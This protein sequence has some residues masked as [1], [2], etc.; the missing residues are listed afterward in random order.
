MM[1]RLRL[2]LL[3]LFAGACT[4]DVG[5]LDPG[6]GDASTPTDAAS[7]G[8]LPTDVGLADAGT[9][10][11]GHEDVG[12][13]DAGLVRCADLEEPPPRM[14]ST[15]PECPAY[16]ALDP[17]VVNTPAASYFGETAAIQLSGG[18]HAPQALY[19]RTKEE[20][21]RIMAHDPRLTAF[22][23]AGTNKALR[24]SFVITPASPEVAGRLVN[25]T[26]PEWACLAPWV[27]GRI[28]P[29]GLAPG[30]GNLSVYIDGTFDPAW[31]LERMR[32]LDGVEQII[33][34][35]PLGPGV[36]VA[37]IVA[38]GDTH[39]Y[40]LA[41]SNGLA[42]TSYWLFEARDTDVS[43]LAE[44]TVR[45]GAPVPDALDLEECRW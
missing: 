36:P 22:E 15:T 33:P 5:D 27:G 40:R 12:S 2:P 9:P 10:D 29:G 26:H 42:S 31:L 7:D 24:P 45:S 18:V 16:P 13:S 32:E 28:E 6:H 34:A 43:L 17:D 37:C 44:A 25:E 38:R 1:P 21:C 35:L 19:H 39:F 23:A 3:A 8:G 11:I 41:L 4:A 30:M 14:I 20:T